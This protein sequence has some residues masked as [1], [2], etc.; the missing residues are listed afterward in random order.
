MEKKVLNKKDWKAFG[1]VMIRAEEESALE[2]LSNCCGASIDGLNADNIGMCSECKEGCG[3]EEVIARTES[4]KLST[5]GEDYKIEH[6]DENGGGAFSIQK[7]IIEAIR[8]KAKEDGIILYTEKDLEKAKTEA[9]IE[10][11]EEVALETRANVC[12]CGEKWCETDLG[13][14][15]EKML[16]NLKKK[17]K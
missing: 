1:K 12:E 5:W 7:E 17:K 6:L 2:V 10:V 13:I 14:W 16:S 15:V 3:V 4:E 8:V 9:K 11:L